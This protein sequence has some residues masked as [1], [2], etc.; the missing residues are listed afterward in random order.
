MKGLRSF[1]QGARK[2]LILRSFASKEEDV[3]RRVAQVREAVGLAQSI[4]IEGRLGFDRIDIMI[5]VD[6]RFGERADCGLT[7]EAMRAAF[8]GDDRVHVQAEPGDLFCG[9]LN[10]AIGIQMSDGVQYSTI[11]SPD[12]CGYLN[13]ETLAAVCQACDEGALAAGVAIDEFAETVREGRLANTFCCWSNKALAS[14]GLFD[15][16]AAMPV[17]DRRA[18]YRMGWSIERGEP[19]YYAQAG[20]EEILPLALMVEQYGKCL[21]PIMPRGA[22]LKKYEVPDQQ[23]RPDLWARHQSKL[24]TKIPR[25]DC[26]L[27]QAGYDTDWLKHGVMAKYRRF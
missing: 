17:D 1:V 18:N 19:F 22:G 8:A 20:V 26:F 11:L 23:A 2:G 13:E 14:V 10:N 27:A 7:A 3:E 12:A 15:N 24:G 25:Q 5:F 21:A 9:L 16:R 6:T 4:V